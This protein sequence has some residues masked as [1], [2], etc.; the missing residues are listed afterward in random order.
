MRT[1]FVTNMYPTVPE[2]NFG[3]IVRRMED[4]LRRA[5]VELEVATI[6]G[7][8]GSADYLHARARVA[9][10][11][12]RFRPEVVHVHFG[13]SIV[14][15]SARTPR[16]VSFYGDDLNG[17][18]TG[19][20]GITPKSRAG[21][22]VSRWAASACERSIAVSDTLRAQI[23]GESARARC[24]VIRDA[25]DTTLFSPGDRA[26]ARRRLGIAHDA[27]LV[28]FPHDARVA[29]KRVDL[30][31]AAE[32]ALRAAGSR[33]ALWIVNG[34]APDRM[35]DHYRAADACLVTS[36]LEGGPSSVKEALACGL[37]VV[38][39]PVGDQA[40]LREVSSHCEIADRDPRALAEAI[41]RA[42]ARGRGP[43]VCALPAALSLDAAARR[44]I[45]VYEK[46]I[47]DRHRRGAA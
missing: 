29:T 43:R 6:A 25:V 24:T 12:E 18:A 4:A 31:R 28:L 21:R 20:G 42:V 8:R 11:V 40:I 3:I 35:P 34:V 38:S 27:P 46:A 14:A 10:H 7:E 2:S 44:V 1:L 39:V 9:R 32:A 13:Y 37:P 17:T 33:A 23:P 16:V 15:T 47:A 5:G 19:R 36:D 22:L 30:A 26:E 45:G 41:E